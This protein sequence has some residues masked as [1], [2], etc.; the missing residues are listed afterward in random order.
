[1]LQQQIPHLNPREVGGSNIHAVFEQKN[2]FYFM[3]F[4]KCSNLF[5]NGKLRDVQ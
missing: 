3:Q 5:I 2:Q 1:M 4:P